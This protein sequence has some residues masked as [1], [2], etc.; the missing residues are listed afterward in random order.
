MN[1]WQTF[2]VYLVLGMGI[3]SAIIIILKVWEKAFDLLLQMFDVKKE[4]HDFIINKYR[5]KRM[6][7]P[8]IQ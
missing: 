4:F 2:C 5:G 1:M 6:P 8:K 3:G 7:K